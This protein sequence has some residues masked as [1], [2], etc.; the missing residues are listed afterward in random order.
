MTVVEL[1]YAYTPTTGRV[2]IR[3]RADPTRTARYR[4]G[5]KRLVFRADNRAE[6]SRVGQL[7]ENCRGRHGFRRDRARFGQSPNH[8]TSENPHGDIR[9]LFSERVEKAIRS[10]TFNNQCVGKTIELVFSFEQGNDMPVE[11]SK[12]TISFSYPNRF[13]ITSTA[14]LVNP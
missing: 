6:L 10:S 14:V 11:G 13:T 9:R 12:Q 8:D 1:Y 5:D 7:G 2:F 4:I 3:W